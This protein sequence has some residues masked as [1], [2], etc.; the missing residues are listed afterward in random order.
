MHEA[1]LFGADGELGF[2]VGVVAE[3][4][5]HVLDRHERLRHE[6]QVVEM[7]ADDGFAA[8]I[9]PNASEHLLVA[10]LFV[11]VLVEMGEHN[12]GV[13]LLAYVERVGERRACAEVDE[14]DVAEHGDALREE[15]MKLRALCQGSVIAAD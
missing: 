7:G 11:L 9:V 12:L 1:G 14:H 8:L 5:H 15:A 13:A 6:Q 2:E 10:I 3:E 4:L